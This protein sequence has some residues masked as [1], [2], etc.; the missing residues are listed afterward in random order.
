MSATAAVFIDGT[1]YPAL[2]T[3]FFFEP[4]ATSLEVIFQYPGV[5]FTTL[6]PGEVLQFVC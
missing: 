5:T 2:P 3:T 1:E 6:T 4:P